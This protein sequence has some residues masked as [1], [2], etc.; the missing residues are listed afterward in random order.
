VTGVQT[1]ALPIYNAPQIGART[2]EPFDM[3]DSTPAADDVQNQIKNECDKLWESVINC[4]RQRY[5]NLFAPDVLR[6][7]ATPEMHIRVD[8]SAEISADE[9]DENAILVL[10]TLLRVTQ[11]PWVYALNDAITRVCNEISEMLIA[12]NQAYGNS[13]LVPIRKFSKASS[14]EQIL[15]RIDDKLSRLARGQAA[16]EDIIKDLIGYLVLLRIARN[17]GAQ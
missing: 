13:A 9:F 12:K 17:G 2:N 4:A 14:V 10:L 15:V 11:Q 8:L 5:A 7:F 3:N 1:C 6:F 16:G